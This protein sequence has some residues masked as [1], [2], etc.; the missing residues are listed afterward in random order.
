MV[1]TRAK[2]N[3]FIIFIHNS[4]L[5]NYHLNSFPP[6]NTHTDNPP[7]PPPVYFSI[8]PTDRH[9]LRTQQTPDKGN[10]M[11]IIQQLQPKCVAACLCGLVCP[12]PMHPFIRSASHPQ[13][14]VN[15]LR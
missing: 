15:R 4:N 6:T 10:L 3:P 14:A 7:A 2:H 5:N 13:S 12:H 1:I 11:L 9:S 8:F